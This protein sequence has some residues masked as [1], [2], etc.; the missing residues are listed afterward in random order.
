MEILIALFLGSLLM[1]VLIEI[2]LSVN[3]SY[4]F[5]NGISKINEGQ[6]FVS[7]FNA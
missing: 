4:K 6:H 5:N 3:T 2:Y 7:L 1:S